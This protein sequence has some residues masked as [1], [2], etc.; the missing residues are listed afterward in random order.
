MA[1]I[2][3]RDFSEAQLRGVFRVL[4][5][6]GTRADVRAFVTRS[7]GRGVSNDTIKALRE[8]HRRLR[9]SQGYLV[10]QRGPRN[11]LDPQTGRLRRVKDLPRSRTLPPSRRPSPP[12]QVRASVTVEYTKHDSRGRP[13][14][15]AVGTFSVGPDDPSLR[16]Q[17][18]GATPDEET[19]IPGVPSGSRK[20][21]ILAVRF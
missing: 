20:P 11:L 14:G 17:L 2:N 5:G 13:I 16:E 6:G 18:E 10:G 8:A 12:R 3:N 21:V 7:Q 15:R 1:Q 9:R 4:D 19:L